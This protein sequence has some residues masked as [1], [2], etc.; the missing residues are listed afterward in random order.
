VEIIAAVFERSPRV[1]AHLPRGDIVR[2][3]GRRLH[4]DGGKK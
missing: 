4:S 3:R 1:D 2:Q